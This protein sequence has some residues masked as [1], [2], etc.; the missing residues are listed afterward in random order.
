MH[1]SVLN[2]WAAAY[3]SHLAGPSQADPPPPAVRAALESCP[4]CP[5]APAAPHP[6]AQA[7]FQRIVTFLV[8]E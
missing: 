3:R 6:A 8:M 7:S 1:S 2:T 5:T 4:P